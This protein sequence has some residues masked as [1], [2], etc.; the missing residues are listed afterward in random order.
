MDENENYQEQPTLS[1][2]IK[3]PESYV[4]VACL[5]VMT[6]LLALGVLSRATGLFIISFTEE[7][8]VQ[9]FLVMSMFTISECVVDRTHMGLSLITDT[10]TGKLQIA[11]LLFVYIVEVAMFLFLGYMGINMVKSQYVYNMV[12]PV[13]QMKKWWFTLAFPIGSALFIL[14]CTQVLILDIKAVKKK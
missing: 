9:L 3:C 4:S 12:T 8:V 14:R 10:F 2:K 6:V 5:A 7:L 11:S 13:L 1:K